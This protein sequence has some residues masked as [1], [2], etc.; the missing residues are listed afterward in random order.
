[1]AALLVLFMVAVTPWAAEGIQPLFEM[2]TFGGPYEDWGACVVP[3]EDGGALVCGRG[4]I[5][6]L[7]HA[8]MPGDAS[9][10][11]VDEEGNVLW[12]RHYGGADGGFNEVIQVDESA[13]A[14]AGTLAGSPPQTDA[15]IFYIKV[16]SD[17]NE[18][19][20]HTYG[21]KGADEGSRIRET[22]DGGFVIAG[23]IYDSR[24]T[25]GLHL[26]RLYLIRTDAQ[27]KRLWARPYGE[28]LLYLAYGLEETPDGGFVI[29]GWEALTHDDRVFVAIKVDSTG[30]MEWKRTWDL[31]PGDGDLAFDMILTSDNH[32][33]LAGLQAAYEGPQLAAL[34]KLD[35]DGN[36]VWVKRYPRQDGESQFWE[37][38]EDVDGGYVMA[39]AVVTDRDAETGMTRRCGLVL[40]TDRDGTVLWQATHEDPAHREIHFG[41]IAIHPEGGY[42]LTGNAC[43]EGDDQDDFLWARLTWLD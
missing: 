8:V 9:L 16:D 29:S 41:G 24:P 33:V 6:Y 28:H 10:I 17:G 38:L 23:A 36:E 39:G 21:G 14:A 32:L 20:M 4:S 35:L 15:D 3:L 30:T 43:R 25:E 19:W 26:G 2:R 42:V 1:M 12:E 18:I 37:I 13:F 27:G 7:S 5:S 40:K 11:R 22:A 34:V 31:V